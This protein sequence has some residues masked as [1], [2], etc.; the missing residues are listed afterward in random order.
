MIQIKNPWGDAEIPNKYSDNSP[1][2]TNIL[3]SKVESK[4]NTKIDFKDDGLFFID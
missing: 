4:I 3:K 2:W 1:L